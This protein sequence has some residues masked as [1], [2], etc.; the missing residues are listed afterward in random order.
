MQNLRG[1]RLRKD[2]C[3]FP[4]YFQSVPPVFMGIAAARHVRSVCTAAGPVTTSRA[5]A[6]VCLASQVPSAMKV[7]KAHSAWG[8]CAVTGRPHAVCSRASSRASPRTCFQPPALD[9]FW[10]AFLQLLQRWRGALEKRAGHCSRTSLFSELCCSSVLIGNSLSWK[11]NI[12]KGLDSLSEKPWSQISRNV[13]MSPGL[14]CLNENFWLH[15]F[16]KMSPFK[17]TG[18]AEWRQLLNG[19]L[20][21]WAGGFKSCFLSKMLEFHAM[22]CNCALLTYNLFTVCPSGRFGKN[23]AGVCTCTNNGTC[24]PIDRSCQCYPGWI[25]SDCSQ[26]K[27]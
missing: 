24:N 4:F 20:G 13:M 15:V 27:S 6:T 7:T 26:R 2:N 25:G 23:C 5:C 1:R 17:S 11:I 10:C 22:R 21:C 14:W 8:R 3:R 12:R 16:L 18:A 9:A 19:Q